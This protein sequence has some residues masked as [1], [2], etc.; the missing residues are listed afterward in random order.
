MPPAKLFV[1]ISINKTI[2]INSPFWPTTQ[3]FDRLRVSGGHTYGLPLGGRPRHAV[4]GS[5]VLTE[6]QMADETPTDG[7][8]PMTRSGQLGAEEE[9][10][11]PRTMASPIPYLRLL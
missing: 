3:L 6:L 11:F 4:R 8:E 2:G 10:G 9:V 1:I 7:G 5:P